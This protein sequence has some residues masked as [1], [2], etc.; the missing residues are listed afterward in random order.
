M[1]STSM[2]SEIYI[3]IYINNKLLLN[4]IAISYLVIP[5]FVSHLLIKKCNDLIMPGLHVIP[6]WPKKKYTK[7]P[8]F[9]NI[10]LRRLRIGFIRYLLT[11]RNFRN[12]NQDSEIH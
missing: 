7:R 2:N 12:W 4:K 3:L 8:S 11:Y 10:I 5:G 6:L 1:C 9:T